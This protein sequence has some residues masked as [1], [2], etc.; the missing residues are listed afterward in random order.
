MRTSPTSVFSPR[1]LSLPNVPEIESP[2]RVDRRDSFQR[3]PLPVPRTAPPDISKLEDIE[4]YY[5]IK[6]GLK[7]SD[8][9]DINKSLKAKQY[10]SFFDTD[11]QNAL[12]KSRK[13]LKEMMAGER[14][15]KNF[16]T[17]FSEVDL[18]TLGT[19]ALVAAI[20]RNLTNGVR[21]LL[22][23]MS[24]EQIEAGRV[25][26]RPLLLWALTRPTNT[27]AKL[28]VTRMNNFDGTG[29]LDHLHSRADFDV[30]SEILKRPAGL[31]SVFTWRDAR[32]NS[33]L[34]E[35]VK[36][37]N[38][39]LARLILNTPGLPED[40]AGHLNAANESALCLALRYHYTELAKLL[41]A[42]MT[43]SQIVSKNRA[44]V[45]ALDFVRTAQDLEFY[46]EQ[47]QL[48]GITVVAHSM[49]ECRDLKGNSLLMLAAKMGH[50]PLADT[51]LALPQLTPD[52]LTIVNDG[53]QN[54]LALAFENGHPDLAKSLLKRMNIA[55]IQCRNPQGQTPLQVAV[56]KRMYD[57]ALYLAT[58]PAIKDVLFMRENRSKRVLPKKEFVH[59]LSEENLARIY[60]D[61]PTLSA[62]VSKY[63]AFLSHQEAM[64]LGIVFGNVERRETNIAGLPKDPQE[65]KVMYD[66]M[67]TNLEHVA[68]KLA[69]KSIPVETKKS[70][71]VELVESADKCITPQFQ[72]ASIARRLLSDNMPSTE[73]D[74]LPESQLEDILYRLRAE[75]V[76]KIVM[77]RAKL[78][79]NSV[80]VYNGVIAAIGKE[81]GVLDATASY[82]AD[83]SFSMSQAALIEEFS[84][85][86]T[87]QRMIQAV[88]QAVATKQISPSTISEL[89]SKYLLAGVAESDFETLSEQLFVGPDYA[90]SDIAIP[91]LLL[92]MDLL[93]PADPATDPLVTGGKLGLTKANPPALMRH[94]ASQKQALLKDK[95][96][97]QANLAEAPYSEPLALAMNDLQEEIE[98]LLK[99]ASVPEGTLPR[100]RELNEDDIRR[101]GE[102]LANTGLPREHGDPQFN[103]AVQALTASGKWT[104]AQSTL[105]IEE[106]FFL[107]P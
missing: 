85:E 101:A 4:K 43:W 23:K 87:T 46:W 39:E 51:I 68:L 107:S 95:L 10:F 58:L 72:G 18:N 36:R 63:C 89:I 75:I 24:P 19:P 78:K 22:D 5:S 41:M 48:R 73:R 33:L 82:Q 62:F 45:G 53:G 106:I 91:Y 29:I 1:S 50:G 26:G 61:H 80:H 35:A 103:T 20:K 97:E 32:G 54:A 65:R 92:S 93:E 37:G 34:I 74:L 84:N 90:L 105:L 64:N 57:V 15:L 2:V 69:D 104:L 12:A 96:V 27:F 56:S 16:P 60:A 55:Q 9:D 40:H 52:H 81:A 49:F 14:D 77:A 38:T 21:K 7:K 42:K 86:Y 102:I 94:L 11:L 30:I 98:V 59:R 28:L 67:R 25:E 17:L 8:I 79:N 6:G 31:K 100:A 83:P 3:S 76:D 47:I 44:G 88:I 99:W 13:F 66:A 71:L 70:A